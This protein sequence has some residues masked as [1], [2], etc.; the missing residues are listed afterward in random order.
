MGCGCKK[1]KTNNSETEGVKTNSN[2]GQNIT[3]YILK[4]LGF[5]VVVALYPIISLVILWVIFKTLVLNKQ[6]NL[7]PLL[8]AIGNSFKEKDDDEDIEDLTENDVVML[9]VEEVKSP[10]K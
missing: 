6:I 9:D 8:L 2:L 7:K 4:T 5:L 3:M 10:S 1:D